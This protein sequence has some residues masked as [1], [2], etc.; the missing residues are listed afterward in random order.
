[1][2]NGKGIDGIFLIRP[3]GLPKR[4]GISFENGAHRFAVE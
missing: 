3:K 4:I 2:V 1:M